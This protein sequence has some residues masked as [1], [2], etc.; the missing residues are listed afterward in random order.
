MSLNLFSPIGIGGSMPGKSKTRSIGSFQD[1]CA[2]LA[3]LNDIP[4]EAIRFIGFFHGRSVGW[5]HAPPQRSEG[6]AAGDILGAIFA[7][8]YSGLASPHRVP[9][10]NRLHGYRLKWRDRK[11]QAAPG[12][13]ELWHRGRNTRHAG[14]EDSAGPSQGCRVKRPARDPFFKATWLGWVRSPPRMRRSKTR[15][16]A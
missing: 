1:R 5:G 15:A 12:A 16:K 9:P 11:Q 3:A 2:C 13:L 6:P 4:P 8:G 14:G 10:S 7:G